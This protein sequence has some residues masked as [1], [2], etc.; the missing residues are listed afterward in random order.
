MEAVKGS[1]YVD[2]TVLGGIS[3]VYYVRAFNASGHPSPP[4]NIVN[5][6][7]PIPE[8]VGVAGG[9]TEHA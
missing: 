9:V 3:Y 4:S 2:K 8:I 6:A 5:F 7:P 1:R